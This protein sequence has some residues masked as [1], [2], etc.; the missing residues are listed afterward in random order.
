MKSVLDTMVKGCEIDPTLLFDEE[1]EDDDKA[2]GNESTSEAPDGQ[3]A[4]DDDTPTSDE[5]KSFF[6]LISESE[7]EVSFVYTLV[8][9]S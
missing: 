6:K 5:R 8:C 4:A 2:F 7:V 1:M 3:D 9:I